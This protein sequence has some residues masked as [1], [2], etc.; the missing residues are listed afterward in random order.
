[1][2]SEDRPVGTGALTRGA[3]LIAGAA[4]PAATRHAVAGAMRA[5]IIG[6]AP[7]PGEDSARPGQ[8]GRDEPDQRRAPEA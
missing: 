2:G 7:P 1:M 8:D 3:M 5:L 6:F 4:D